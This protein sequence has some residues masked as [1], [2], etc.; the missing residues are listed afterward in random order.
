MTVKGLVGP[1]YDLAVKLFEVTVLDLKVMIQKLQGIPPDQQQI[2][3]NGVQLE[4]IY[5]L[6]D[7]GVAEGSTLTMV[8]RLRTHCG[9]KIDFNTLHISYM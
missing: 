6:F 3:F 7:Y 9:K 8:L 4:D 1:T 5:T 2:I